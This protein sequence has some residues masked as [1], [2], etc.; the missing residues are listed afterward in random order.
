MIE[1]DIQINPKDLARFSGKLKQYINGLWQY[2][3]RALEKVGEQYYEIVIKRMGEY[4]G[5]MVFTNV[6]WKELSPMWLAE[7]RKQGWVEEIWEATG[8]IKSA[9]RI[10]GVQIKGNEL[11]LFVG[12]KNVSQKILE[13][14]MHNEFSAYLPDRTIPA[15]PLFEPAKRE[16]IYNPTEHG[17]I[18]KA[19]RNASKYAL[20]LVR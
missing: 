7:K 6:Y 9:V 17:K 15:R 11:S 19:F 13:K 20:G 1:F 5:G 16:M 10:F 4:T 14:A 18:I 3:A 2:S 8:E 12:L